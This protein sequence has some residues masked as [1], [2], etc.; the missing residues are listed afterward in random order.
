MQQSMKCWH[1]CVTGFQQRLSSLS[2][3]QVRTNSETLGSAGL[4]N[5]A[6]RTRLRD[7]QNRVTGCKSAQQHCVRT[8]SSYCW[9]EQSP[10]RRFEQEPLA[11]RRVQPDRHS[12]LCLAATAC[13]GASLHVRDAQEG[14][15]HL[16]LVDEVHARRILGEQPHSKAEHDPPPVP[17][18]VLFRPPKHPAHGQVRWSAVAVML[19][20]QKYVECTAGRP[21]PMDRQPPLSRLMLSAA[22]CIVPLLIAHHTSC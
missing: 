13:A 4:P 18:L 9:Q 19:H 7:V 22:Y 15:N 10:L 20:R 6:G 2:S 17:D 8:N 5:Q 16:Q 12:V 1:V 21:G 3:A 11:A 14:D